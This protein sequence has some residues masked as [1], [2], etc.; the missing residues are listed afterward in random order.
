MSI[1][2]RAALAEQLWPGIF[3]I[4]GSGYEDYDD[5]KLDL[6]DVETSTKAYET[7]VMEALFGMNAEKDAGVSVM[8]DA[9]AEAWKGRV[10]MHAYGLGF[11]VPREAIDDN[12]YFDLVPKFTRALK[13]SMIISE[14]VRAAAFYDGLFT[15][16]M[17]GDGKPGCAPDHPIR[18]GS[19]SN[20]LSSNSDLNETS[21]E[22]ATTQMGGWTDE[23]GLNVAIKPSTVSIPNGLQ[24][25]AARLSQ[26]TL[27]PG[28]G[29]NDINALRQMGTIPGGF[30][31]NHYLK[32]PRAWF[33]RTNIAKG[34][35]PVCWNRVPLEVNPGEGTDQQIMKVMAY[36]RYAFS[37][38]NPRAILGAPGQPV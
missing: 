9:A 23:R 6:F 29:D 35:G 38:G 24:F 10:E 36:Q 19:F 15:T 27:R 21:L 32:D 16:S 20:V 28:T 2:N 37:L 3:M 22:A 4:F 34:E 13:R 14:Q 11:A 31:L 30:K 1:T 25:T 18:D 33:V 5:E 7:Y 12:Q 8:F 26:T 17:T